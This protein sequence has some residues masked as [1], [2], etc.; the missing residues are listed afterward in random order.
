MRL[1]G[2]KLE[3]NIFQTGLL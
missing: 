2:L 3:N 1:S